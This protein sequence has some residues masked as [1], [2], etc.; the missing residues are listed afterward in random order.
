MRKVTGKLP[1]N[2]IKATNV[3]KHRCMDDK[4]HN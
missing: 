3:R 1:R 4:I 2:L